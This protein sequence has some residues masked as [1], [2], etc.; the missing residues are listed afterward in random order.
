MTMKTCS[1]LGNYVAGSIRSEHLKGKLLYLDVQE[2]N[3]IEPML[4]KQLAFLNT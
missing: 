1:F 4:G 2:A 3:L